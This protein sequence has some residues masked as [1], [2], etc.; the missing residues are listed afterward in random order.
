MPNESPTYS[1]PTYS[2][3]IDLE[4][5]IR[6]KH[7]VVGE[8]RKG[9]TTLS[10]HLTRIA[11]RTWIWDPLF[12][13]DGGRTT[14]PE[15]KADYERYGRGIYSHGYDPVNPEA[16]DMAFEEFC[17]YALR[18]RNAVVLIDEP[19]LVMSPNYIPP[20]FS[21]FYRFGH[22]NGV[23]I[24]LATHRVTGDIPRLCRI[25]H[26]VWALVGSMNPDELHELRSYIGD[27]GIAF[28]SDF[29]SP[30]HWIWHRGPH[31]VGPIPRVPYHDDGGD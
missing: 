29:E 17:T 10:D 3:A 26:H 18:L 11:P 21:A 8:F 24:I 28:V 7:L 13:F 15:A 31:H 5:D 14:M 23:G 12:E 4:I 9:K 2:Q 1:T 19:T 27:E 6:D 25:V 30:D 22:K 20:T 16:M